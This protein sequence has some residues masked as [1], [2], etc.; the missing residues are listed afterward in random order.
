MVEILKGDKTLKLKSMSGCHDTRHVY[1]CR[2]Y[3]KY[4]RTIPENNKTV[5]F[6]K[7]NLLTIIINTSIMQNSFNP[8]SP[9]TPRAQIKSWNSSPLSKLSRPSSI[10]DSIYDEKKNTHERSPVRS[11]KSITSR[12]LENLNNDS[13][14]RN[15]YA[16]PTSSRRAENLLKNI[17]DSPDDNLHSKSSVQTTPKFEH[18]LKKLED[19]SDRGEDVIGMKGRL[20]LQRNERARETASSNWMDKQRENL[21]AYEYLCRIGEAKE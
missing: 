10:Y 18:K 14:V 9:K 17:L 16:S 6:P 12:Y 21:Q 13:P 4:T 20:K 11:S 3:R 2:V 7:T 8:R 15:R 5:H 19:V 1:R